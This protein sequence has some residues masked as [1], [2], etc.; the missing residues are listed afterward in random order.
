[1]SGDGGHGNPGPKMFEMLFAARPN[2]D[3]QIHLTHSL[4]EIMSHSTYIKK[5]KNVLLDEL[6]SDRKKASVLRFP[7][8]SEGE[9][10]IDIV[11]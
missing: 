8:T 4:E 2:L 11:L 1:V 6:F 3:Y 9:T 10:F 7:D 5:G